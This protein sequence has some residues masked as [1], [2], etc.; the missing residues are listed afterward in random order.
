VGVS[1]ASN[2][3]HVNEGSGRALHS[4]QDIKEVE[5]RIGKHYGY[6]FSLSFYSILFEDSQKG[7]PY[8]EQGSI[9]VRLE[10]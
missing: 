5:K 3:E 10:Y 2:E 6:Q 4:F 9:T 1:S 7:I 8:E